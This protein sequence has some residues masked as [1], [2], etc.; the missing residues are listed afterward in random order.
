MIRWKFPL[1][2]ISGLRNPTAFGRSC[3]RFGLFTVNDGHVIQGLFLS[4][5]SRSE[6]FHFLVTLG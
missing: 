5:A 4:F 2:L 1:S 3:S 6:Q